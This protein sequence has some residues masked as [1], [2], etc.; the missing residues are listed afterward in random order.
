LQQSVH[1]PLKVTFGI[2]QLYR[3]KV[4]HTFPNE[5]LPL[6]PDFSRIANRFV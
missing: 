5:C 2:V 1:A 3:L 4:C 6:E